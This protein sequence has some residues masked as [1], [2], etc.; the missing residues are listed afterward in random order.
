MVEATKSERMKFTRYGYSKI[1][2]INV[3][4]KFVLNN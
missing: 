2:L 1:Y 3:H 4:E